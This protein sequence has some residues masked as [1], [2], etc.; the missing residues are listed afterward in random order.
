MPAKFKTPSKGKVSKF[1]FRQRKQETLTSN[2]SECLTTQ[3]TH[4]HVRESSQKINPAKTYIG[5]LHRTKRYF[6]LS[7]PS[8]FA[9]ADCDETG[10]LTKKY[11]LLEKLDFTD[12]LEN[13]NLF[14]CSCSAATT[15][16]FLRIYAKHASTYKDLRVC[17][18]NPSWKL[19]LSNI[20]IR[21]FCACTHKFR[22]QKLL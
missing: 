11:C 3:F 2:E 18:N 22:A 9:V 10:K 7:Q 5:E 6:A 21:I 15:S 17:A 1:G 13:D 14:T 20:T 12:G 19:L 16:E 8:F 4:L